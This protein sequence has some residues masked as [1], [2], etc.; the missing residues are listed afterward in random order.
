MDQ[1][2]IGIDISKDRLDVHR[3]PDGAA[4][5]FA[6]T[7]GGLTQLIRWIGTTRVER[8]VFEATGR[9]H[10]DLERRLGEAGLPLAKVNPRQA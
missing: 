6:N 9:Y 5:Q 8:V 2:T 3:H 7:R 10:R 4:Q 1:V